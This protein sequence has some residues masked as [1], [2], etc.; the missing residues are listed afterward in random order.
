MGIGEREHNEFK[1]MLRRCN[2]TIMK[3]CLSFTDRRPENIRDLYQEIACTIWESWSEFR[4]ESEVKTWVTRIALNIAGME[5]RKRKRRP[6]FVEIDESIYESIADESNDPRIQQLYSLID[7]LEREEDRKIIFLYID[8]YRLREIADMT[9]LSE[10][11]VKK[12][13]QRIKEKLIEL[14]KQQDE[15]ER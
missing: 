10:A 9:G 5:I 1:E 12:R 4:G 2:S 3:V 6:Q 11:V 7:N 14:K 13:V 15:Y 8:K